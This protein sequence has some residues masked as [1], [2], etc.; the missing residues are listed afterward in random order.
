M[1]KVYIQE[2]LIGKY[3]DVVMFDNNTEAIL[4]PYV[5]PEGKRIKLTVHAPDPY[6]KV[7]VTD[8]NITLKSEGNFYE[9]VPTDEILTKDDYEF[10]VNSG[11]DRIFYLPSLGTWVI[12][13]S[14]GGLS[15]ST[16]INI[17][18]LGSYEVSLSYL[19]AYIDVNYIEGAVC[20]CFSSSTT[21]TAPNDYGY[22]R[23]TVN[24][25]GDWTIS[26]DVEG[27][28]YTEMVHVSYP[29]ELISVNL[30]PETLESCSWS[31]IKFITQLGTASSYFSIGDSK[32]INLI[33]SIYGQ[34]YNLTDLKA[35]LIDFNHNISIESFSRST[36]S[37]LI[38]NI[39]GE[40]DSDIGVALGPVV[41]N[42]NDTITNW[43]GS[44]FRSTIQNQIQ[45]ALDNELV[46]CILPITKY[47]L[48]SSGDFVA[49]TDLIFLPSEYEILGTNS[50]QDESSMQEQYS[51]YYTETEEDRIIKYSY[52]DTSAAVPYWTRS[53]VIDNNAEKFIC[54][55]NTGGSASYSSNARNIYMTPMFA[56]G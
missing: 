41:L 2:K 28:V 42:T 26:I 38:G 33:G 52:L 32:K 37:F 24:E 11:N 7:L 16:S 8:G 31:L 19:N 15:R 3:G 43:S 49:T 55:T 50:T 14:K 10:I 46:S 47:T 44:Y 27:T 6:S 39:D 4:T 22:Y 30:L 45:N 1:D 13:I 12:G 54:I 25:L 20:K 5:P 9:Y 18:S 48:D 34:D 40:N 23:F 21:L 53:S 17:E 51:Y 29:E 35:I 36:V 56:I